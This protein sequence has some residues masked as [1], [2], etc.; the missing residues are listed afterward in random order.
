MELGSQN[1]QRIVDAGGCFGEGGGYVFVNE[2]AESEDV[3]G[4]G[5]FFVVPEA[6]SL[7]EFW[8]FPCFWMRRSSS[9]A[10]GIPCSLAITSARTRFLSPYALCSVVNAPLF[11]AADCG[12]MA[13]M[14]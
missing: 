12:L 8:S 14:G 3:G 7:G 9:I 4:C 2:L 13:F 1:F 5:A 11:C 6:Y 10:A